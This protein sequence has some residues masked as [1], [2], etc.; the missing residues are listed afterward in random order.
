MEQPTTPQQ[1]GQP[2]THQAVPTTATT[3][4]QPA[5]QPA[6]TP[7]QQPAQQTSQQPT[8][9]LHSNQPNQLKRKRNGG[10]G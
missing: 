2:K 10:S 7:T 5:Q 9:P 3:G 1:G 8:Q 6:Q 4:Q